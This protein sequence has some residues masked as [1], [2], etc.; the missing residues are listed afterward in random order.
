M[1]STKD[2][3]ILNKETEYYFLDHYTKNVA[4]FMISEIRETE[5][6]NRYS[7]DPMS[8]KDYLYKDVFYQTEV[9]D[10]F[11]IGSLFDNLNDLKRK[12]I[13]FYIMEVRKAEASIK[14][15]TAKI[16]ELE[17]EIS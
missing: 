13:E 17:R 6:G 9:D 15:Y 14:S 10:S 2:N 3:I 8:T 5:V 7:L 12:Q 16:T 1:K 4:C 11:R